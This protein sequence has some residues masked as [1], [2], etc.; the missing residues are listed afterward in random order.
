MTDGRGGDPGS[1]PVVRRVEALGAAGEDYLLARAR[2]GYPQA[3]E[4][5]VRRHQVRAYTLAVRMVDDRGQAQDVVQEAFVRAWLNLH[6]FDGRA[7]F[8]TWLHRIVVNECLSQLRRRR[9]VPA[10]V[11]VDRPDPH[12]TDERVEKVA[13]DEALHRSVQ[14]LPADQ[15]A[16]LVL[17]A[18]M[19]CTYEE[20][21]ELLGTSASTVRGRTARARR[22]LL[23]QM[24]EWA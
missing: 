20:A 15:R 3:F 11:D 6:R 17:T 12:R 10:A 7:Q 8:S 24:R 19:D 16:A 5:M 23:Q 13:R 18:F 1:A 2:E 22:A 14:Q 21:A 4:E 9:P